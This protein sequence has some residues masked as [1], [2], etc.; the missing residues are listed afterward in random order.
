MSIIRT[1]VIGSAPL[2]TNLHIWQDRY[3]YKISAT[4]TVSLSLTDCS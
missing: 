1:L 3:L 2:V 4:A